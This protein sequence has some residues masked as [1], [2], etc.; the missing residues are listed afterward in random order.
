M[1]NALKVLC[2]YSYLNLEIFQFKPLRIALFNCA[3]QHFGFTP[4]STKKLIC[5]TEAKSLWPLMLNHYKDH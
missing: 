3:L 2:N 4:N 1:D 5:M